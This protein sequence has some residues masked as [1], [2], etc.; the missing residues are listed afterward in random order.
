[1]KILL[2]S[3]AWCFGLVSVAIIFEGILFPYMRM[4]NPNDL[5]EIMITLIR[6]IPIF[7]V[8]IFLFVRAK[9]MK[10]KDDFFY[11][12]YKTVSSNIIKIK[13]LLWNRSV[14][15]NKNIDN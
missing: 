9:K 7:G 11:K 1:M 4:R 14:K 12:F 6:S 3:L 2:T 5:P 10:W 15:S 8:A 13:K